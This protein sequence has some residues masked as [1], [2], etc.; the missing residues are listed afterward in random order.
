MNFY[1]FI[2]VQVERGKY[3]RIKENDSLEEKDM[4]TQ[5]K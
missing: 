2:N 4:K 1:I 3:L 5:I